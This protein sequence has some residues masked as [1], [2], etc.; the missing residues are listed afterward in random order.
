MGRVVGAG[1][2]AAV[3]AVTVPYESETSIYESEPGVI[4]IEGSDN[5]AQSN[6][7][8]A[9]GGA[10]GMVVGQEV[11]KI[12]TAKRAQELTIAMDQG[13]TV[14]VVQEHREPE[15]YEDERVKVLTTRSGES[16]VYHAGENPG[17]DPDTN[18]YLIDDAEAE[19]DEFD[20]VTW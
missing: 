19:E 15:F 1:I 4:S 13:E 12:I 14:V 16:V 7:A 11:E 10:V 17:L 3:G 8:M 5:R 2:G 9:V 20:T 18:A 6:A